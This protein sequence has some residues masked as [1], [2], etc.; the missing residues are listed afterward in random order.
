[1]LNKVD[2]YYSFLRNGRIIKIVFKEE[3]YFFIFFFE[4]VGLFI[5]FC[6]LIVYVFIYLVI[7]FIIVLDIYFVLLC[8][9]L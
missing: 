5:L 3:Q 1:M 4:G 6:V 2:N 9:C 8:E 7:D